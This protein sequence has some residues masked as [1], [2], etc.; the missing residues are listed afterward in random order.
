VYELFAEKYI[1]R[2]YIIDQQGTIV[3]SG[4]NYTEHEFAEMLKKLEE[5]LK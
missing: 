3:Y 2:N 1:P 5:L 4:I